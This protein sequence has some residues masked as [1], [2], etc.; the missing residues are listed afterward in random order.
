MST[1]HDAA[2]APLPWTVDPPKT[3]REV[4]EAWADD[5][6][7]FQDRR[8]RQ[9]QLKAKMRSCCDKLA[10]TAG[11]VLHAEFFG[12]KHPQA[13]VENLLLYNIGSLTVA[14]RN[15]IRFEHGATAPP[16]PDGAE[17]PFCYRYALAPRSKGFTHWQQGRTLASFNWTDLGAFTGEKKLAPVWLALKRSPVTVAEPPWTPGTPFGVRIHIRPPLGHPPV[18][19]NLVKGIFD[20]VICALHAH[21]DTKDLPEVVKRLAAEL[22]ADAAEIEALL[23]DQ[24][25][26]VLG[27][28]PRLVTLHGA[29]VAWHPADHLCVA[30]ELLPAEPAGQSSAIKGEVFEVSR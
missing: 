23:H 29:G 26:A 15:G 17:Y 4:V 12:R 30:G 9:Q 11:Q 18:W 1:E 21:T 7:R 24:H 19:G 5:Y 27:V 10:P 6:I 3:G 25:K 16:A 13:D 20:G 2:A 14:G 8:P 28:V 22:P